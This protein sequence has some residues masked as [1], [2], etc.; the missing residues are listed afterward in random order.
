LSRKARK[1][2]LKHR[3]LCAQCPFGAFIVPIPIE[4]GSGVIS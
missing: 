4:G 1:R 3:L 2:M